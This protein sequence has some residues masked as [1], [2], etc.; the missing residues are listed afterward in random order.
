MDESIDTNQTVN[1]I[2]YEL[3]ITAEEARVGI[4]KILS[5]HGK[6]LE[7]NIPSGA[8]AG[9]KIKLTNALQLTDGQ[10][11]DILIQIKVKDERIAARVI[12]VND[13]NFEYQVLKSKIPVVVDFWAPWCGP[14]RM[15]API[16]E[17]VAEEYQ[18][19]VK[20]CKL[21]VDENHLA[22]GK[23]QVT[24][25]PLL[26]FFKDGKVIEQIIGAVSESAIRSKI[27]AV[28]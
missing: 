28:L 14:C 16:T 21:N 5:R 2:R 7:V 15:I 6:R 4:K 24:S 18:G 8:T 23:Y 12:E 3:A 20:F 9:S 19:L 22:A 17:K 11:G 10:P 25:I 1:L 27:E 13:A 26:L